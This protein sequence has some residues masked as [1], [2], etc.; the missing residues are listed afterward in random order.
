MRVLV[1]AGEPATRERLARVI[2]EHDQ[3]VLFAESL[4]EASELSRA[5][6]V[7][8]LVV[9][10]AVT[11]T[12]ELELLCGLRLKPEG[13]DLGIVVVSGDAQLDCLVDSGYV[14]AVLPPTAIGTELVQLVS[15]AR[16]RR[17]LTLRPRRLRESQRPSR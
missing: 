9:G 1:V 5:L 6:G 14:D 15:G 8:A 13:A 2:R 7:D 11:D 12:T 10:I 3:Q 4:A 16:R 17:R